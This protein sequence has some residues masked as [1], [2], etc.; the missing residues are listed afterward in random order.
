MGPFIAIG[1]A[2]AAIIILIISNVHI[3]PQSK[4][5][6]IERLGAYHETWKTGIHIKIPF[7]DR[8]ARRI[9]LHLADRVEWMTFEE[10]MH[11]VV[12]DKKAYPKPEF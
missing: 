4:A 8:I 10:I 6:V 12:S 7:F 5:Y 1:I 9:N 3:V 2:I 11:M